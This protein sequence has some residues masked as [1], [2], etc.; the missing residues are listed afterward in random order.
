MRR[1]LRVLANTLRHTIFLVPS[2]GQRWQHAPH[3]VCTSALVV[4]IVCQ[5]VDC[6]RMAKCRAIAL[7]LAYQFVRMAC[8]KRIR[9]QWHN[10]QD[11]VR[12]SHLLWGF[13]TT[14][15]VKA[16]DSIAQLRREDVID[17]DS[18]PYYF[19]CANHSI[20][21]SAG[22]TWRRDMRVVHP[23]IISYVGPR[24]LE[25]VRSKRPPPPTDC[26]AV[27]LFDWLSAHIGGISAEAIGVPAWSVRRTWSKVIFLLALTFITADVWRWL[28]RLIFRTSRYDRCLRARVKEAPEFESLRDGFGVDVAVGHIYAV[29]LGSTLPETTIACDLL[30]ELAQDHQLQAEVCRWAADDE[31]AFEAF[32]RDRCEEYTFFFHGK[33]RRMPLTGEVCRINHRAARMPW[34]VGLRACPGARIGL[35]TVSAVCRHVLSE[36]ELDLCGSSQI[37]MEQSSLAAHYFLG[38]RAR[39]R[40]LRRS[41]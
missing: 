39:V 22:E 13:K 18:S 38:G 19:A 41:V 17:D 27:C 37:Q 16:Q 9:S 32:I 26:T 34:G 10:T 14:V 15:L 24:I 21:G 4:A 23:W 40:L 3:I 2:A 8:W 33:S 12:L 36:Y 6:S 28:G 7:V 25:R 31:P 1:P 5:Y 11:E 30:H 35:H 29:L 20:L